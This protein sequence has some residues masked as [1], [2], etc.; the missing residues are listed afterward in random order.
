MTINLYQ[1]PISSYRESDTDDDLDNEIAELERKL[2]AAKAKRCKHPR[3][4][5]EGDDSSSTSSPEQPLL[6]PNLPNHFHLLLS[7]SALPLG[8]FAFSSGLESYLA[9]GHKSNPYHPHTSFAAFLPLSISSYASTTLP[10]VLSAH[11]DPS[12]SNL[13]ELDDAQD[14]SIIC[15]VG[16]RASVAQGRALLGIWERSFSQSLPPLG[17]SVVTAAQ[18][19]DLKAFGLLVK[20][21]SSKEIPDASAHL[22]PLFG[23]ICSV[24]GLGLQQTAYIFLFGHVKALVSAAVRAGM[25]GPYQAQKILAGETVQELITEMIKREWG[26]KVERAGQNVPV[27]DLWFGR[28]EVLYSRIFNS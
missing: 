4:R 13:V 11:R 18:M 25:F 27:M 17:S 9:H 8:S 3:S 7:D 23:A 24:V 20:R 19:G 6:A 28:H 26:T 2:A 5:L 15:T 14:A 1:D 16:R 22:A 21:G 10:F 12:L